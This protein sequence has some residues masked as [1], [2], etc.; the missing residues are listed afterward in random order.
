MICIKRKK[1][2]TLITICMVD[3]FFFMIQVIR[4]NILWIMI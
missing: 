1:N 3:N 4:I 2:V